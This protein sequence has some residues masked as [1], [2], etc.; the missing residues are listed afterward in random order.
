MAELSALADGTLTPE[1][2]AAIRQPISRSFELRGRYE[3]Q[4]QA[5]AA[6]HA[7]RSDRAPARLRLVLAARSIRA[8]GRSR[9]SW[10]RGGAFAAAVAS[11]A[12]AV[13]LLLPGA[14]PGPLTVSQA[15]ALALR[16]PAMG[17]P[18]PDRTQIGHK[19][20]RDV[21][22]L[23]FPDWSRLRWLATGQRIDHLNHRLAVTVYYRSGNHQLAYTIVAAPTLRRPRT[24]TWWLH[25]VEL[26]GFA[27]GGRTIVT[28]RRAGH[29]CVLAGSGVSARTM[30]S[31]ALTN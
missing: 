14:G 7:L 3:H 17:P 27:T 11:V 28:W 23:Y 16:G 6:L 18:M 30:S 25:G 26:Q 4:R 10:P 21:D 29:T 31:L 20:A 2:A 9:R 13:L 5:V 1:R 8:R 19:L 12:S 22:E 24:R 15:S